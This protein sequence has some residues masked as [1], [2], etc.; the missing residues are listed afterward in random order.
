MTIPAKKQ[1]QSYTALTQLVMRE[2]EEPIPV[3]EITRRV[4][5][6]RPIESQSSPERVIRNAISQC[7]LVANTGDGKY[8][9]YPRLLKGSRI[10]VPLIASDLEQRRIVFDDDARDLLWPSFFAGHDQTDRKPIELRLPTG[11][12]APLPL[13]HFGGGEWG[14]MGSLRFWNWLRACEATGG[15][16]LI[17]EAIDAEA[18][19]YCIDLD[20]ASVRDESAIRRRTA[21]VEQEAREHMW[22]RR[23]FSVAVWDL[24]KHLLATGCYRHPVPPEPISPT[25]ESPRYADRALKSLRR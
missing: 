23:A 3:A 10:R 24:A 7:R 15:D 5:R 8:W 4:H 17:L 11:D 22:K 6:L 20:A 16:A 19:R 12:S 1:S 9:W 14:T 25:L 18:R 2:A 13:E 21:E